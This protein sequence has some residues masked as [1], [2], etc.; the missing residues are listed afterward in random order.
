MSLALKDPSLLETRAFLGG[1][2]VTTGKTFPVTNPATG[3]TIAEVTDLTPEDTAKAI[4]A[5][6]Q[7]QKAWRAKTA[8]ERC[9]ILLKWN[10]LMLENQEDLARILTAEMGKPLAEARGEI[11][12]GASFIQWFA[13]EARRVYGDVIPGHQSDKRIVVIKQ[14]IGVVGSITPWNFP[15]AMIARKVGPALASGCTFVGRPAEKTPLSALAMAVLGERAGIPKGVLSIITSSN[16][17][18]VGLELCT[19]PKVRKLTFTGSTEVGR[20]LMTQC[21]HDIKKLS[22]E[23]GGNAP[24]LVFD[25]ADLDAAV[26]GAMI[27]KYRNSGQ[28]CVCANR[29]YAQSGVAEEFGRKL[30]EATANLKV[31]DGMQEGTS[32]GPLIDGAALEKVEDH[33]ADAVGKGATVV[34]GG[35]RSDLGG[36]FYQPTVLMGVAKGMKVLSEETFGPVAPIITF[37]TI[38]EGI[39]LANDTEFGLAAYFY[40]RDI[41]TVWKVAEEIESGMVGINT[42]LVST[43]EAPFGGI[44]SSGLGREGSKYGMDEFLEI[45]YL[46]MSV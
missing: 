5:A 17:R 39:E 33:V 46:C 40:A 6:Y 37:D 42:G 27:A 43:A 35:K 28:T 22:L 14:P 32:I 16:S 7:A 1:E 19:N 41:S 29:I 8:K 26:E 18:G 2:W 45:K 12:Y 38:D 24:F 44:K 20:I 34:T 30:A 11:A 23:L 3:E 21:A 25:D 4:D 13:E 10:D 36:T 15:N 31:G 9:A